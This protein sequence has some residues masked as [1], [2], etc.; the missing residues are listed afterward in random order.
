MSVLADLSNGF[1]HGASV[2]WEVVRPYKEAIFGLLTI[3]GGGFAAVFG[4][5]RKQ[6]RRPEEALSE[7][8]NYVQRPTVMKFHASDQQI[9]G[10]LQEAVIDLTRAL[11]SHRKAVDDH[12]EA[13]G[14]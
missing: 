10:D 13:M 3:V 2:T 11:R 1:L 8:A 9:I 5:Y 12:R 7:A 14:S 6:S 4:A